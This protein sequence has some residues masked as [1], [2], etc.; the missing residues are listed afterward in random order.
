[1]LSDYIHAAMERAEYSR[2]DD[3]SLYG[4][5]PG[6]QGVWADG[7]TEESVKKELQEVLEGWIAVRLSHNLPI[8]EIDGHSIRVT[9]VA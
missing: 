3:G 1:M 5:I 8:P 4:E 6:I 9:Q 2:L 7:P